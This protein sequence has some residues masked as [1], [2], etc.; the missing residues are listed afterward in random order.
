MH[1]GGQFRKIDIYFINPQGEICQ[2]G[3]MRVYARDEEYQRRLCASLSTPP[4]VSMLGSKV[5]ETL[6]A[7]LK[8]NNSPRIISQVIIHRYRES[9]CFPLCACI[10]LSSLLR[11]VFHRIDRGIDIPEGSAF[12]THRQLIY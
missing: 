6:S 3:L 2:E 4:H 8:D 9:W 5:N 12:V 10:C 11:G 7:K 1:S